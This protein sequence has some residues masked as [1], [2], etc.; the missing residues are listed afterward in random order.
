MLLIVA[1]SAVASYVYSYKLT[2]IYAARTQVLLKSDEANNYQQ[3]MFQ[4]LGLSSP[5]NT[6]E[7]V[8]N[9]IRI[10]KSSNLIEK[11]ISKLNLDISYFIVGRLKTVEV[12]QSIPFEI[13]VVSLNSS[14]YE[15]PISLKILDEN[16]AQLNFEVGE[17]TVTKIIFFDKPYIDSDF[18]LT[19]SRK[20]YSGGVSGAD[21][22]FVVHD[23]QNLVSKYQSRITAENVDFT[24]IVAITVEDEIQERAV[25][26]LDT[27]SREYIDFTLQSRINVNERTLGYIDKQLDGVTDI[28]N[29]I[30][31]DLESYKQEKSILDLDKEQKDYFEKLTTFENQLTS[32][33]LQYNTLEELSKYIIEGKDQEFLP[34]LVYINDEFLKKSISELYS[35]A[36]NKNSKLLDATEQSVSVY[37]E[38]QKAAF[39]KNNLLTYITN[40]KKAVNENIKTIS[41]Q[42]H[43]SESFIKDI[44]S[45]QRQI[46]NIQR[47]QQVN[48]K[49]YLYLLEKKAEAVIARAGI[50]PETKVIESARS[51]GIVK[52]DRSKILYS[53][54]GAGLIISLMIVFVRNLLYSR[55]ESFDE[56]KALTNFPILGEIL[57]S[58]NAKDAY[59][60]VDKDP[61]SA[62]TE[63]FRSIRTNLEY[64]APEVKSKVILIT[65]NN[66]G[67]GKTFCTIN[68]GSILAKA[69]KK[70]LI[71][72]LDLHKPK[73]HLGLNMNSDIGVTSI[74]IGKLSARDTIL[75]TSIE[76]MDVILSGPTPPNASELVL[77]VHLAE[78]IEYAK[79]VYDYIIVD[80][81]PVGLISDALVIMK[82]SDICLF[83]MN[84]KFTTKD[85]VVGA[86]EI[87]NAN[88]ITNLGFVLNGVKRKRSRYYY[89]QYSYGY[90]YGYGSSYNY[91]KK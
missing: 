17:E 4:G 82:H 73:V 71:I 19:V 59:L 27:L 72:E 89:N 33:K 3:Q 34:P 45:K 52:P 30:E 67:E 87:A 58:D 32:L 20:F 38:E 29:N 83:V 44:P 75:P 28:L 37:Q 47:K 5:S 9:E 64:L 39:L 74:L 12:Y 7:K 68:L 65:S 46:L 53:F 48:E 60:V 78:M 35:M 79:S 14:L 69:S 18:S 81:P 70:V 91:G 85:S 61:K 24:A 77:S 42:I 51:A 84:T 36:V 88:K 8:A 55:I 49:M 40:T 26:F 11:A 13:S 66:P 80:T 43:H 16:K 57:Q 41:E 6:Y 10:I 31:N 23:R 76:N 2:D 50:V 25:T 90:G 1:A 56:L 21:Y 15:R 22:Q 86:H 63:T 54:L 62:I